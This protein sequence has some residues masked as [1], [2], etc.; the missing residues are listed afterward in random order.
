MYFLLALLLVIFSAISLRFKQGLNFNMALGLTLRIWVTSL[1]LFSLIVTV[2]V[3]IIDNIFMSFI[4]LIKALFVII[5][6]SAPFIILHFLINSL[7]MRD[8]F[9]KHF[10]WMIPLF[11]VA[12]SILNYL[13][14]SLMDFDY[15]G[16]AE[17]FV[18]LFVTTMLVFLPAVFWSRKEF[19]KPGKGN[20]S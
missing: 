16:S 5:P 1:L 12:V 15:A 8:K 2:W 9:K 7:L 18:G 19:T 20:Y 3:C 13:Y 11:A 17:F 10:Q 6:C 14:W 4:V